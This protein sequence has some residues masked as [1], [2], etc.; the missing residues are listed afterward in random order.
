MHILELDFPKILISDFADKEAEFEEPDTD[1]KELRLG[2][3]LLSRCD[4]NKA[5]FWNILQA[6]AVD[7][8]QNSETFK[9]KF[10]ICMDVR[11]G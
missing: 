9:S 4:Q 1:E 7:L 2:M 5:K 8:P 11:K 3:D 6:F 10:D